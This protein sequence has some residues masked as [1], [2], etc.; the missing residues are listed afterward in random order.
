M[1]R[2]E[3]QPILT[4]AEMRSAEAAAA[5]DED[6][7]YA[8]M[9]RA[10]AAVADAVH[11]VAAGAPIQVLCGPGNNGG[12]GYVAAR[13]LA[14]NGADVRVVASAVQQTALAQRARAS[15]PG[16]VV[17]LDFASSAPVMVDALFGTGLSRDL[18]RES[19]QGLTKALGASRYR[20]AVDLPSGLDAD[21][22]GWWRHVPEDEPA[23]D[24][25][26]A[27]GALKPAH[28]EPSAVTR[29]GEVRVAGLGL[30]LARWPVR[31]AGRP[32]VPSP[33][34]ESHKYRR[35][36][37]GVVAGEMPGA[38]QLAATAA[39]RAGAGYVVVFGGQGGGPASLVHRPLDEA[40]FRD[41]RLGCVVIGPGLGRSAAAK[42]WVD[43]LVGETRIPLVLDADAL[44]LVDP[45]QL[46]Q[47]FA[48][49]VLTPHAGELAALRERCGFKPVGAGA[50]ARAK[51]DVAALGN[52]STT[53]V[54][55][56]FTTLVA[57]DERVTVHSGASTWLSTAG[58]GDVLAGAIGAMVALYLG[59]GRDLHDAVSTGVWLHGAAA[60]QLG[61]SFIADDLA[62]ALSGAR[63]LI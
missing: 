4:A 55:K 26:L 60:R 5:P 61:A 59:G 47:R 39:A 7:L 6:S 29:L 54:A 2:V 21:S 27:L 14:A 18:A 19:Q 22:G 35:G 28:V 46:K 24:L 36:M 40:A 12:D 45:L 38:A 42:R 30:D 56:G 43:H 37:V 3:G 58:T 16:E 52:G 34:P 41:E 1:E 33:T 23:Y 32:D 25:T 10:G 51:A 13:I 57:R 8:L 20:V 53:L 17:Q 50:I 15:W 44:H 62:M 11:R 48:P 31:I 9:E 49:T 63:G